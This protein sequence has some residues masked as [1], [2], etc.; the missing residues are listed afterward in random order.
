MILIDTQ[1]FMF[2]GGR[3]HAQKSDCGEFLKLIDRGDLEV[4]VDAE[5]FQE[6]LHRFAGSDRWKEGLVIYSQARLMI[7]TVVPI[8]GEHVDAARDLLDK[9]RSGG[10]SARDA[11]HAAVTMDLGADLCAVDG[12]FNFVKGLRHF[13]PSHYLGRGSAR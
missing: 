10:L 5:V 1:V 11:I 8:T 9:Y 13:P 4:A 6:M 3:E 7:P 2:A 12:H